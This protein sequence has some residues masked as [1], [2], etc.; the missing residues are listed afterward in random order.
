MT[1]APQLAWVGDRHIRVRVAATD[2]DAAQREVHELLARLSA[3]AIPG[4]VDLTPASASIVLTVGAREASP[5]AVFDAARA[6]VAAPGT[7]C[8]P[9]EGREHTIGVSYAPNDAPDLAQTAALRGMTT[10]EL[11]ALHSAPAYTVGFIGFTPGFAYL[12][13][14]PERLHTARLD[15][16]RPRVPAGSVAIAGNQCGIYPRATPGGWRIIGRTDA[17]LF[18]PSRDPPCLLAP[19]DT[20]RFRPRERIAACRPERA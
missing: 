8:A 3:A 14:L 6:A 10:D 16:P 11:I 4:L 20:V 7:S 15:S 19:G 1:P 9:R 2:A 12:A 13:G 5:R 17:V 18:D